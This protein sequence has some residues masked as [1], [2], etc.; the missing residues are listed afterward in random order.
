MGNDL[1]VAIASGIGTFVVILAIA[2]PLLKRSE[3]KGRSRW[4]RSDA[5]ATFNLNEV[6]RGR[7]GRLLRIL[8]HAPVQ[9][10]RTAGQLSRRLVR[11]NK[12][13]AIVLLLVMAAIS[14]EV[15]TGGS[16]VSR[17]DYNI[18]CNA[19]YV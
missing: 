18:T 12:P 17:G 7:R 15:L 9:R 4:P 13:L 5:Q 10:L 16:V 3:K 2:V 1:L 14:T 8:W 19:P 11:R 6:R